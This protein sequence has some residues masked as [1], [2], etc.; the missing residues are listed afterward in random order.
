[1]KEKSLDGYKKLTF[2]D[3]NGNPETYEIVKGDTIYDIA[4]EHG[5]TVDEFLEIPGNEY[6]KE[7][8][9]T[10]KDGEDYILYKA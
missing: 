7:R 5:L 3:D 6:L 10:S 4:K 2:L 1:M 9:S 8:R